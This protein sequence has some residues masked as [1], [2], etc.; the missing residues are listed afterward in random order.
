MLAPILLLFIPMLLV[1]VLDVR[2]D[3]AVPPDAGAAAAKP[4]YRDPVHDGAADA[5]LIR[6]PGSGE[7]LMFYTNRRANLEGLEPDDVSWV[8]G[9]HIGMARSADN[10]RSWSYAGVADI[11]ANC[12]G[13]TLWAPEIAE[14]DGVYH[15]WVTVVPGVFKDWNAPRRIV[16]LTSR[17][18]RSW[19]CGDTLDL[20]SDRVIDASVAR[21]GPRLYRLWYKDERQGSRILYADSSDLKTWTVGGVAVDTPGEGPKVFRWKGRYWMISDPWKGLLVM[22]SDDAKQWTRQPGYLLAQPGIQPT[23]RAKGQHPDVV[24]AGDRAFLFYFTHQ[25]G[26]DEAAGDPAWHKRTV[27]QLAELVEKDGVISVDREAAVQPELTAR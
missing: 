21:L 12:T 7:W 2:A 22:R 5:S 10:G 17:D 20:G 14:F 16:H 23:D 1:P 24:V 9:T 25:S 8:H 27:I 18:L 11:P 19:E 6:H 15:L 26:E 4:L 13:P 3:E